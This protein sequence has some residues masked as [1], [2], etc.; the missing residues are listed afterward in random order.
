MIEQLQLPFP[1]TRPAFPVA[2]RTAEAPFSRLLAHVDHALPG[3]MT[4][5]VAGYHANFECN[6]ILHRHLEAFYLAG[7]TGSEVKRYSDLKESS[8]A[9]AA[10]VALQHL[11]LAPCVH[12]DVLNWNVVSEPEHYDAYVFTFACSA[13]TLMSAG[14]SQVGRFWRLRWLV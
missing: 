12:G 11:Y 7:E 8:L 2:V 1:P 14:D 5:L 3:E 4:A 6:E 9:H 13:S 10:R